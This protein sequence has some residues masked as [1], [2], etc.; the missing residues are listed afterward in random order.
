M[1][2]LAVLNLDKYN[3]LVKMNKYEDALERVLQ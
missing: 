2:N 1:D 3:E